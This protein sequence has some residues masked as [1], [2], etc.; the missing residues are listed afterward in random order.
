[1]PKTETLELPI[2]GMDCGECAQTVQ[3]A[4]AR[5]PGVQSV[6][7]YL[8][9]EKAVIQLD[10]AR[11]QLQALHAVVEGAG[12]RVPAPT[13][14]AAAPAPQLH[15]LARRISTLL[16]FV[17][18]MVLFVIVV[19]EWFGLLRKLTELVPFG[20]GWQLWLCVAGPSSARWCAPPSG[21]RS[22]RIP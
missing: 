13:P 5:L 9:S 8:A 18:G 11:V 15:N 16:G 17:F 7:V 19:G 2:A 10:P 20:P 12:Y 6:Q 21:A 1:M 14:A 22:S 3:R 4:I